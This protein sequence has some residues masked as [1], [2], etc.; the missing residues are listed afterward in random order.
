MS[1]IFV[2]SLGALFTLTACMPKDNS[3]SVL[4]KAGYS[5]IQIKGTRLFACP[6]DDVYSTEFVATSQSGQ[7]VS[8]VVCQSVIG[9]SVIR[10]D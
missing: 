4:E 3:Y 10:I 8:G 5:E 9:G 6:K 2:I 7:Q 1:R